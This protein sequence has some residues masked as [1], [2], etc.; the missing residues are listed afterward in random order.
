MGKRGPKAKPKEEPISQAVDSFA[1][2]AHLGE[3]GRDLFLWCCG[4]LASQKRLTTDCLPALTHAAE[5]LDII[6][7]SDKEIRAFGIC[8]ETER[9]MA[10]NPA[11]VTRSTHTAEMLKWFMQLGL[12]PASRAKVKMVSRV[13]E[14][15]SIEKFIKQF[16]VVG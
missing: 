12:T 2:P 14:Q 4:E 8:V 10:R 11:V 9:G 3:H 5:C 6:R 16:G 15:S 13:G 1:V 7:Q